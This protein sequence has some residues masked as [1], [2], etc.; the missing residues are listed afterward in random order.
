LPDQ[1]FDKSYRFIVAIGGCIWCSRQIADRTFAVLYGKGVASLT[2][3][4]KL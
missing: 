2:A 3:L 1:V 4:F